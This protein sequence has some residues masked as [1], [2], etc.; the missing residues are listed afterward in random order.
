MV[1]EKI[2]QLLRLCV[3]TPA[4]CTLGWCHLHRHV[5]IMLL[6]AMHFPEFSWK[7]D[8][9]VKSKEVFVSVFGL[10]H[11]LVSV[12][13]DFVEMWQVRIRHLVCLWCKR[14]AWQQGGHEGAH[15]FTEASELLSCHGRAGKHQKFLPKKLQI[16]CDLCRM[17]IRGMSCDI[18]LTDKR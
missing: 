17:L 9:G 2:P 13:C 12:I 18:Q 14:F 16:Q 10:V 15:R 1:E 7:V 3:L 5:F 11:S 4:F 6:W 8:D